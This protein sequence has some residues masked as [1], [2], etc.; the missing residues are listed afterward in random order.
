MQLAL[1]SSL[2]LS[3]ADALAATT[4]LFRYLCICARFPTLR[5]SP[6]PLMDNVWH[7]LLQRPVYY[8]KVC[9]EA[10]GDAAPA[11]G[12]AVLIPHNPCFAGDATEVKRE[13]Y[14]STLDMYA[15][16]FG[17]PPPE[18]FWPADYLK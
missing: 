1:Q 9:A 6:S 7:A 12:K 18:A 8:Q 17:K 10:H 11:A 4:E 16:V 3:A 14:K 13:R 5:L 15:A 2:S